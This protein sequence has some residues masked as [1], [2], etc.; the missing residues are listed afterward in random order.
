MQRK[1][2]AWLL[3]VAGLGMGTLGAAPQ[4]AG[5]DEAPNTLSDAEA[6]AGWKLLFD[7]KTTSGW[8]N[9]K[10]PDI[11][12]GW[13]VEDGALVRAEKGAGDIITD[14]QFG[15]FELVLDYKIAPEGNSGLMYHVSE[16]ANRPPMVGPEVQIQDNKLGHDPQLSGWLYQL[17][18]SKEDA[19]K[20]AGEWNHL[21]I[22][23]TPAKCEHWMNGVKYCEYVIGSDDWDARVAK[24]KFA[25]WPTFGKPTRGHICLQDHNSLVSFRNIK[26]RPIATTSP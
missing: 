25:K 11:S 15:A 9:F 26:I 21:R 5:A 8:R 17:Y 23:I 4:P 7:G 1:S 14:E 19:T 22:L 16:E 13:K 12:P 2:I 18:P 3:V 20:P 24:S 10:K 6:K